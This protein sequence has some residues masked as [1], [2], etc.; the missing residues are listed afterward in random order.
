MAW[1]LE[2]TYC[3]PAPLPTEVLGAWNLDPFLILALLFLTYTMRR[4]R[5]GLI[6]CAVLAVAFVSPLCALSAAL[7]SARVVHHV[8]LVAVAAPLLALALPKR[9]GRGTGF[10]FLAFTALLWFWHL[11]AAYDAALSNKALYWIM[12][13]TLLGSALP[14]WH[15]ILRGGNDP[16][17]SVLWTLAAFMAMGLLGA[18]LTFAPD[19]LY[20]LHMVAPLA[21]GI[22][23]LG[24]QQLAGLLMWVPA[25][26]PY[27]IVIGALAR[28][29]W[30]DVEAQ[31][32]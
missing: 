32:A 24:D 5:A 1:R 11:P 2:G 10:F 19:P 27:L 31:G 30:R 6:A 9:G 4:S 14:F 23:P 18:L 15:G 22:S 26:L 13:A 7:F 8:L 16:V 25:G 29:G 12:Q 21:W 3:G 20:A 17:R 28:R